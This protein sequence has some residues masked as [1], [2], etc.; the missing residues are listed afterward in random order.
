MSLNLIIEQE[1]QQT[2]DVTQQENV[3]DSY[4]SMQQRLNEANETIAT[5]LLQQL[6]QTME[7]TG[8]LI[9]VGL[10]TTATL[11]SVSRRVCLSFGLYVCLFLCLE[12]FQNAFSPT[13]LF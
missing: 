4:Q 13:V 3:T 11:V 7:T 10:R 12:L 8:Q 2:E 1:S 9:T 6:Q 5:S